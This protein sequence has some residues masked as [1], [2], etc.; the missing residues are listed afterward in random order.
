MILI[1]QTYRSADPRRQ[2]ELDEALAINQDSGLFAEI[3]GI[4]SGPQRLTFADLFRHGHSAAAGT[5][6]VVANSDIS[7]DDSLRGVAELL[8][9][10]MLVALSRWNDGTAPVMGGFLDP[11][12]DGAVYSHS[13][14]VWIFLGGALPDFRADFQ[15]GILACETRLAYEAAA[16]G[17]IVV[18]PA[19]SIRAR[20][21]HATNVRSYT[22]KDVYHGPRL[23]PRLAT[24]AAAT[25]RACV[26]DRRLRPRKRIVTL[27]G[28]AAGF[29]DQLQPRSSSWRFRDVRFRSPFYLRRSA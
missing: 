8:R 2:A 1:Q 27:D 7:F 12:E 5:V 28:T 3:H 16:A 24:A 18:D 13:Q 23:F 29:T 10:N 15:L 25:A 21:H 20:H 17:V 4:D 19:L 26:V 6:C 22:L 11:L 14:D 9:P